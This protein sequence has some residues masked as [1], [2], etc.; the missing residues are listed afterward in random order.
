MERRKIA[1][2]EVGTVPLEAR[3][4]VVANLSGRGDLE[5]GE[6]VC[7]L[8]KFRLRHPECGNIGHLVCL[9]VGT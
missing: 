5:F 3:H 9:V 4:L 7:E 2:R 8:F 1:F 6:V